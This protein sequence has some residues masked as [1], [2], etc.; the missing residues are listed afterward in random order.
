MEFLQGGGEFIEGIPIFLDTVLPGNCSC[1]LLP[2]LFL[3]QSLQFSHG[4][5]TF[6]LGFAEGLVSLVNIGLSFAN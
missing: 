2:R 4:S 6:F 3:P 5:P 1:D